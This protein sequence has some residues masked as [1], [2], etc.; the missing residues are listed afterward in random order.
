MQAQEL[1]EDNL[2]IE[3]S[4]VL[5]TLF[6][7][8][9]EQAYDQDDFFEIFYFSE[10]D[11]ILLPANLI[12]PYLEVEL[13]FNRDLSLL[14]IEKEQREVRIDLKTKTYLEHPEWDDRPPVIAGGEFYLAKEVFEYLTDYQISWNNSLQEV[15][16]EGEF[17]EDVEIEDGLEEEEKE[18]IIYQESEKEV[19]GDELT[20]F[21]LS[22]VHYRVQL[23]LEDRVLG[24]LNKEINGD[25]NFYGRTGNW[26]YYLNNDLKYN[27]D[28]SEFDYDLDKI[29]F[30]Y[31]ENNID[32]KSV[33]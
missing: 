8:N 14:T 16:V 10:E 17:F 12:A 20:G 19:L 2:D 31:Q 4:I 9:R 24:G 32:R 18:K 5:L 6:D 23:N 28:S 13:N 22:S 29:R 30:K 3:T 7:I 27:I 26:A 25:L 11:Y 21:Q 15:V 33:V 1:V